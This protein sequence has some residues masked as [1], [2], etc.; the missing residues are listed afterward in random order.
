MLRELDSIEQWGD[1][2]DPLNWGET[3]LRYGWLPRPSLHLRF[4]SPTG[5]NRTR[6]AANDADWPEQPM[7]VRLWIEVQ[8]VLPEITMTI[9]LDGKYVYRGSGYIEVEVVMKP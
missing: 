6:L 7:R 2:T 3:S 9:T 1:C 5:R 4:V 8:E